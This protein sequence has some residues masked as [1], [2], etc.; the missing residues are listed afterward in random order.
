MDAEVVISQRR[1]AE[2]QKLR[3]N[4]VEDRKERD[5]ACGSNQTRTRAASYNISSSPGSVLHEPVSVSSNGFYKN[6]LSSKVIFC[7][8]LADE[9]EAPLGPR[10]APR[11]PSLPPLSQC[12]CVSRRWL[13]P[14]SGA[15]ISLGSYRQPESKMK[16]EALPLVNQRCCTKLGNSC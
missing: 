6:N 14:P 10:T 12:L 16:R 1:C 13:H 2:I 8:S 4:T 5:L 15:P 11:P 3:C 9:R 7:V